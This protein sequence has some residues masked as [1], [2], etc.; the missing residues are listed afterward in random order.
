[1]NDILKKQGK[2]LFNRMYFQPFLSFLTGLDMS[3]SEEEDE[4]TDKNKVYDSDS[5]AEEEEIN[6]KKLPADKKRVLDFFNEATEPELVAIQGKV[7]IKNLSEKV[8]LSSPCSRYKIVDL[9]VSQP[10][11]RFTLQL[12]KSA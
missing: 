8:F 11:V 5:D 1:M 7:K 4:Y 9:P 10:N 6:E 12:K 3:D 2:F